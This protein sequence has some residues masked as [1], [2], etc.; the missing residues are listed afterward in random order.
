M[1]VLALLDHEVEADIRQ[2][3]PVVRGRL[4]GDKDRDIPVRVGPRVAARTRSI[5]HHA[6]DTVG[7]G[8]LG[9]ALEF[10]NQ[11]EIGGGHEIIITQRRAMSEWPIRAGRTGGGKRATVYRRRRFGAWQRVT[12]MP[13]KRSRAKKYVK[14]HKDGSIWANGQT[15]DDIPTGYW[16]WFRKGGTRMRSGYFKGGKQVGEWTTYDRD[17]H[18][19]K[20]T[21]M[22]SDAG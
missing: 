5:K 22:K 20:V 11:G 2:D 14:H 3:V 21:R 12:D 17:G 9:A 13:A 19:Y 15:I 18:V 6:H 8:L 1:Y 4:P 10:A 7:E 16:E